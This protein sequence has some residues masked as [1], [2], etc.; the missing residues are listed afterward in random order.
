MPTRFDRS[1]LSRDVF[2][3]LAGIIQF[4]H[5]HKSPHVWLAL[6]DVLAL[7]GD[8]QLAIRAYAQAHRLGHPAAKDLFESVGRVVKEYDGKLDLAL[9]EREFAAGQAVISKRQAAEDAKLAKGLEKAVFG[10]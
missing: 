3:A 4:G 5:G 8:R 6:G 1:G 9:F 2:V 10:Y 7:D